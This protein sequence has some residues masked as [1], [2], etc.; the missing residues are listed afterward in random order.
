[1][2]ER[3]QLGSKKET[4]ARLRKATITEPVGST[5]PTGPASKAIT[6]DM[7]DDEA[8]AMATAMAEEIAQ[9]M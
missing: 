5:R 3:G 1:M 2:Y 8:F 7:T 9:N 4:L 6:A